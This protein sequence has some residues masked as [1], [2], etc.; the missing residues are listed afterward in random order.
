MIDIA[1]PKLNNNDT[2]YVLVEWLAEDGAEVAADQPLVVIETSKAVEE[3]ESPGAG[4]LHIRVTK[5]ADCG[6]GEVIGQLLAPVEGPAAHGSAARQPAAPGSPVAAELAAAGLVVTDGARELAEAHGLTEAQLRSLGRTL[7]RRADV[8]ALIDASTVDRGQPTDELSARQRAVGVAVS[9]SMRTIPAAA[10]YVK[11]LADTALAQAQRLVERQG[12]FPGLP[13][14]LV[15]AVATLHPKHPLMFA[16]LL[17]DGRVRRAPAAN[18]GVTIDVGRGL[19]V[20][21][22]RDAAALS[23]GQI[24]ERLVRFRFKALRGRFTEDELS[25]ANILVAL[26]NT[27]GIVLATPIVFPGQTCAVCLP[28]T[29]EELALADDGRV[30]VRRYVNLGVV[31]DHRVVNGRDAV[32]FLQD[33]KY[34]LEAPENPA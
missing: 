24:A 25:G 8:E 5:G 26:H 33:L 14:L 23:A 7:I 19:H 9:E 30:V 6:P 20:P 10:A 17:G 16:T 29:Q 18:V 15:K 31:Y 34:L 13:E 12:G 4:V 2:S 28:D 22:I 27:G 21:V 1:V 32:A 11:V 3:L